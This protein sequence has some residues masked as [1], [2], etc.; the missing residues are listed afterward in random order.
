M[1]MKEASLVV[2]SCLIRLKKETGSYWNIVS[3]LY[4]TAENVTI[5]ISDR[6]DIIA[7][8]RIFVIQMESV[9]TINL[10]LCHIHE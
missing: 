8:S 7:L 1:C 10:F 3:V 2:V 9:F 6:I 4:V 5:S